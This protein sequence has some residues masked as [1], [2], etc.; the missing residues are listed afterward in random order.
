MCVAETI[1][2]KSIQRKFRMT[3]GEIPSSHESTLQW[4]DDSIKIGKSPKT[5]TNVIM[6]ESLPYGLW[7][8]QSH[9]AWCQFRK[10]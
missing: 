10:L 5:S 2:D 9:M 4:V 3:S 6:D 1:S 8:L 7:T